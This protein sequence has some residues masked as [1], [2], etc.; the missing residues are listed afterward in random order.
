VIGCGSVSN[1]YLPELLSSEMIKVVSLCDIKYDRAVAQNKQYNI[2][3]QT[4]PNI[5]RMLTGVPF[6]MMVTLTDMQ[7][8]EELN[9]KA[10]LAGKNVWSEK[11]VANTYAA[12]KGLLDLAKSKNLRLWERR[13]WLTVPSSHI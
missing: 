10:L 11:P 1:S 4:Y 13:L 6:D 2:N 7:V 8:H 3:A 9:K 12:G 5:D